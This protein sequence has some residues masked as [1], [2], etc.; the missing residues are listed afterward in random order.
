MDELF[1][2]WY[3]ML[4]MDSDCLEVHIGL[5]SSGEHKKGWNSEYVRLELGI[6]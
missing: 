5:K 6:P 2:I 4:S 1:A 3:S